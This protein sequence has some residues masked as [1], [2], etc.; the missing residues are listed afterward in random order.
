MNKT[1][2]IDIRVE[3]ELDTLIDQYSE[4][5]KI[6]KSQLCR[7]LLSVGIDDLRIMDKT[8][9]LWVAGTSQG[10]VETIKRYQKEQLLEG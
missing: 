9:M 7:N 10:I 3:A 1:C 8:G 4:K 2:K 5:L 6:S